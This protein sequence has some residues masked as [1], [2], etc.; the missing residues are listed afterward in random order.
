MLTSQVI[1]A[2]TSPRCRNKDWTWGPYASG[3]RW[4]RMSRAA[5]EGS[6]T[7]CH[8]TGAASTDSKAQSCR[9]RG[10]SRAIRDGNNLSRHCCTNRHGGDVEVLASNRSGGG[11]HEQQQDEHVMRLVRTGGLSACAQ[12]T[13]EEPSTASD[14]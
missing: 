2:L 4:G 13:C 8:A 10:R 7:P 3:R 5:E 6:E 14:V 1:L 11:G 9:C 12:R